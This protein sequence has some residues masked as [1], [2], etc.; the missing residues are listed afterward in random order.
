MGRSGR[1]GRLRAAIAA[2]ALGTVS[3]TGGCDGHFA[4]PRDVDPA[5]VEAL[6]RAAENGS[7]DQGSPDQAA[8]RGDAAQAA[9]AAD[10]PPPEGFELL[11][12]AAEAGDHPLSRLWGPDA[13]AV[14]DDGEP[15]VEWANRDELWN[16]VVAGVAADCRAAGPA[17]E[18]PAFDGPE[19]LD[20]A[21]DAYWNN[22]STSGRGTL[23]SVMCA[24]VDADRGPV[25]R[26]V[27]RLVATDPDTRVG[28][29]VARSPAFE[30]VLADYDEIAGLVADRDETLA[31][32]AREQDRVDADPVAP[33]EG[34]GLDAA[35]DGGN[36][37]AGETGDR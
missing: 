8:P 37:P 25:E 26:Y 9:A 32:W 29:V 18:E 31:Q 23:V 22:R 5:D 28:R 21:V 33:A 13:F 36:P 17:I 4:D 2:A 24:Y 11:A 34:A 16:E 7:P 3:L 20:A 15:V 19:P 14:L 30:F 6:E 10:D 12:P 1:R 35:S 27:A